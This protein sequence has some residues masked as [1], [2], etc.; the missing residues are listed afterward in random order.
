MRA[1]EQAQHADRGCCHS[2]VKKRSDQHVGFTGK[3]RSAPTTSTGFVPPVAGQTDT[4]TKL[5]LGPTSGLIKRMKGLPSRPRGLGELGPSSQGCLHS[6]D[7]LR[8]RC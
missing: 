7:R 2:G 5:L 4:D 3:R 1:A 6:G 8:E